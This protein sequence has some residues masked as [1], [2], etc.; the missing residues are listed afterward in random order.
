MS[1]FIE[2]NGWGLN[3]QSFTFVM[4]VVFGLYGAW[5]LVQ[6]IR[7]VRKN[8]S[9]SV[10]VMWNLACAF[11]F[12][13]YMSY[14]LFEGTLATVVQSLLRA[15]FYAVLL[16]LICKDR[17]GFTWIEWVALCGLVGNLALSIVDHEAVFLYLSWLGAVIA[18][19]QPW[20]IYKNRKRGSVSIE[21]L[22]AYM[23]SIIFWLSY[24]LLIPDYE[25]VKWASAY[26]IVYAAGL[27]FYYMF[28]NPD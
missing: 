23:L 14:G 13:S 4:I 10:S 18:I 27:V 15:P 9:E 19:D 1:R 25:I 21:L 20:Q 26:F 28:P 24:G 5:G 22:W 12:A 11:M 8:G 3:L 17:K 7:K 16:I 2:I 6:Q